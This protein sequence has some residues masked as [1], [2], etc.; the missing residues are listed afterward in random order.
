MSQNPP[1]DRIPPVDI[2]PHSYHDFLIKVPL[3]EAPRPAAPPTS[4][5]TGMICRMA[6]ALW[7]ITL[8]LA[9]CAIATMMIVGV[10]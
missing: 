2:P 4:R 5:R 9:L 6:L 7:V 10:A 8:V 3:P 1:P